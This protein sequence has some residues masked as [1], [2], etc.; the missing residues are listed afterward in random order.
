[1]TGRTDATGAEVRGLDLSYGAKKFLLLRVIEQA[2]SVLGLRSS[3]RVLRLSASRYHSWRRD[4]RCEL[5]DV[6]SCPRSTPRQLTRAEVREI[7]EMVTSDEFRHIPTG[8][9]ALLAQ[10]LGRVFA[11]PST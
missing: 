11:S 2:R 9:L 3:L 10:R 8:A 6:S 1:M 5:A 7:K 4:S